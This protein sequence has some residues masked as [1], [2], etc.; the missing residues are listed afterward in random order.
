MVFHSI[1]IK[2]NKIILIIGLLIL[3]LFFIFL[4]SFTKSNLNKKRLREA[5]ISEQKKIIAPYYEEKVF[6]NKKTKAIEGKIKIP[7]IMYHY[8]EYVKN[9]SDFIRKRLDISPSIFE[10]TLKALKEAQYDTYFVKEIPDILDG[11]VDYST[12]SAVL[13]FDDGYEDFYTVVF[14]LLKKYHSRATLFI[15]YD[16]IGRKGFLNEKEIKEVIDSGLV[17]IGSHTLDHLSLDYIPSNLA[18]KQIFESKSK[19]EE[20][21]GIT[22]KSFAYPYGTFNQ[23]TVDF[24]KEA[25]YSAAV[26]VISGTYQSKDSL[27]FLSRIRSGLL[28]QD[29]IW[30]IDSLKN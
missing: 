9:I 15:I 22:I 25:S 18:K 17:E 21:F 26:S 8:V 29:V 13:T 14:P 6:R 5:K 10:K 30:S 11:K 12:K 19:L 16:F 23:Q 3:S 24:V 27:F 7:I 28:G 1:K 4:I 2:T 20:E